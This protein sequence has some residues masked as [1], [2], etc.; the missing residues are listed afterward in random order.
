[1]D[2]IP[3]LLGIISKLLDVVPRFLDIIPTLLDII[4]QLLDII[5][6]L[7]GTI[8]RLLDITPQLLD[9]VPKLLDT[10]PTLLGL[11]WGCTTLRDQ[12][13]R[14]QQMLHD[15]SQLLQTPSQPPST[16]EAVGSGPWECAQHRGPFPGPGDAALVPSSR[17]SSSPLSI[18]PI[19][20][21]PTS[22]CSSSSSSDS[23]WPTPPWSPPSTRGTDPSPGPSHLLPPPPSPFLPRTQPPRRFPCPCRSS[24]PSST[25]LQVRSFMWDCHSWAGDKSWAGGD[26]ALGQFSISLSH[27]WTDKCLGVLWLAAKRAE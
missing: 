9:T 23:P 7:L 20:G 15:A 22:G 8:P 17:C 18:R 2:I 13:S 19:S 26:N 3:R 21:I 10:V 25:S 6:K 12:T 1:M 4:P 5:S 24:Q 16:E 11:Q 27:S 14:E